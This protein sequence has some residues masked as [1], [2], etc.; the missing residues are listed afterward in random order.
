MIFKLLNKPLTLKGA[1]QILAG[2]AACVALVFALSAA[3]N[4]LNS[5]PPSPKSVK[6]SIR[7]YLKKQTR[8]SELR[9]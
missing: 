7:S 3:Y 1:L 8:L 2:L 5:G 6:K 4:W 9:G